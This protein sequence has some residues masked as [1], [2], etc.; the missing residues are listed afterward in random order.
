VGVC[1]LTIVEEDKNADWSVPARGPIVGSILAIAAWLVFI[2]AFA[3][4][5]SRSFTFFQDAV[6]AIVSFLVTGLLIGALWMFYYTPMGE[7]RAT[8]PVH[9]EYSNPRENKDIM[10]FSE[11]C[12]ELV[13]ITAMIL[14]TA[15]FVYNQTSNTGFFTS[16]YGVPEIILFYGAGIFG[17]IVSASRAA[18]GNRRTV[19][20]LELVSDVF[21]LITTIWLLYVFPFNFGHLTAALPSSVKFLF[22]WISNDIGRILLALGVIGATIA[23]AVTSAKLIGD[24]THAAIY[25]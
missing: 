7:L 20:P 6:V 12:G 18:T 8:K 9:G 16:A 22:T 14:I 11:R 4:Y 2:L 5:W 13:A 10:S 15:F 3:L 23:T 19:R 21:L 24:R 25:N 17:M 1:H